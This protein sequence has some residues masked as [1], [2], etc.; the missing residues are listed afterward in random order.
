MGKLGIGIIGCG[1]ISTTYLKFAPLFRALEVRAVADIDA[2]AAE[3]RAAE[4]GVRAG[5]VADVMAA[6]D[7]DVIVNLTVP[8]AH[9][10]VSRR[11]LEAG[12]HVYSEKPF[13][14]TLDEGKALRDLAAARGLRVGSAPDTVLGGSHH[15]ARAAIDAGA[16]GRVIAG[17]AHVMSHGM[18][19]WHPN[20]DF[21]FQPGGGPVLDLGPYYVTNLIQLLGPVRAVAA[22]ANASF[23]TRTI[24]SGA[25][26][27]ETVPVDTP[28]NI[29]ALLEFA[30]GAT[31]TL[32][33]SWDVWMHR[34]GN[35]ELYGTEGSIFVPDPNF[36]AG[37][38]EVAD[39]GGKL[40]TI[41]VE[42]HPFGKPNMTDG[43]GR[44]QANYRCA[45]LADMAAAIDAG[46]AHRCDIDLALHAVDV[47]VSILKAGAEKRWVATSTTCE[48]PAALSAAEASALMV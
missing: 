17:T 47:M 14:L 39:A 24:G 9:Y 41:A 10:E 37:T 11:A 23:A 18:E 30:G 16:V 29:H 13:V 3:A 22:M 8:A 33:A 15:A 48:R 32:S 4:F 26:A 44:A 40:R 36:F 34:H 46:R 21:F 25:R 5:T 19:A 6:R 12:K 28:T 1:N 38:V 43:G 35:M 31:V 42:D 20:P 2:A 45:G 27:G 7:V